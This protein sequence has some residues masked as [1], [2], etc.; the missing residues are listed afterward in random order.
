MVGPLPITPGGNRYI[1]TL[2][3][4][5]SKWPEADP[6]KDKRTDTVASFL[7]RMLCRFVNVMYSKIDLYVCMHI[8]M[9]VLKKLK[10]T[11]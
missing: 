1:I 8:C 6:V 3:D 5:F 7:Y 9:F 4:Y 10:A 2:M 11:N